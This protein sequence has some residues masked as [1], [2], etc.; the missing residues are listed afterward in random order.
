MMNTFNGIIKS[1]LHFVKSLITICHIAMHATLK[2]FNQIYVLRSLLFSNINIQLVAL[3]TS[4]GFSPSDLKAVVFD[5]KLTLLIIFILN[6]RRPR[7]YALSAPS[8]NCF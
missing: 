4:R 3:F 7:L 2:Y 5:T 8:F 1:L 6:T